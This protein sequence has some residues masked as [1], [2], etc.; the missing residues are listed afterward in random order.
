LKNITGFQNLRRI[1]F[2]R[3]FAVIDCTHIKITGSCKDNSYLNRN[4]YHSIIFQGVC[5]Y[6][7]KLWTYLI[8]YKTGEFNTK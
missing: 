4:R 2:P 7:G 1:P 8:R 3:T 5:D 6:T